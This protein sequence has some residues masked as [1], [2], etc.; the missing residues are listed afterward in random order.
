VRISE[1]VYYFLESF[2]SSGTGP[3]VITLKTCPESSLLLKTT[4]SWQFASRTSDLPEDAPGGREHVKGLEYVGHFNE[5][6][7]VLLSAEV[8]EAVV[9][10]DDVR[11]LGEAIKH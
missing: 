6:V 4:Y 3:R 10:D 7:I 5:D 9:K 8:V 1:L 11:L 2:R